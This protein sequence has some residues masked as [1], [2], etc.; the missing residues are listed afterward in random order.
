MYQY[1]FY[2]RSLRT[3]D[4]RPASPMPASFA[5]PGDIAWVRSSYWAEHCLE[6]GEPLCYETCELFS[7][8]PDD[9]CRRFSFGIYDNPRFADAPFGAE[10]AFR[11]WGKLESIVYP[12]SLTAEEALKSDALWKARCAGKRRLMGLGAL[13]RRIYPVEARQAFD[14]EKYGYADAA[15]SGNVRD[16][17]FFLLQLYSDET[18]AFTLFFDI[19]DGDALS[20]REGIRISPGYNQHVVN[21]SRA[22]PGRDKLRMK[23]YPENNR[24][25]RIVLLFCELVQFVA[26]VVPVEYPK[27][28]ADAAGSADANTGDA[29]P[30]SANPQAKPAKKV[31][32][33]AWDL[34]NTVWDGTFVESDPEELALRPGV[35]DTM[36]ALDDRGIIQVVVSKNTESEVKPTLD[37]LG[38]SDWFVVLFVNWKPKSQNLEAAADLLNINIDTFALID[39]SSFEREEVGFSLP[40]VRTYDETTVVAERAEGSA[41]SGGASAKDAASVPNAAGA[42]PI[43]A[44]PEFDVPVTSES[45]K[46]RQMYKTEMQRKEASATSNS[47]PLDFLRSCEIRAHLFHPNDDA[48]ILRSYELLQRTNQLNLSGNRYE[49]D[50]FFDRMQDGKAHRLAMTCGDRFGDYGQVLYL[51]AC[52]S[53]NDPS[54]LVIYEFALSC[55]VARKCVE[56]ALAKRLLELFE[57]QG[58]RSIELRGKRTDRNGLLIDSFCAAGFGNASTDDALVLR[59]A[60]AADLVTPD[61]VQVTG[62]D[63]LFAR[64]RGRSC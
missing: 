42:A 48:T 25:A 59:L 12:G 26:G 6:C 41:A 2:N 63:Q 49:K 19:T 5:K 57:P 1:E 10:I 60:S 32:C 43:F 29:A 34:D 40:M 45:K 4:T 64:E 52:V 22:F 11:K 39:D 51:E 47:D 23:I 18:D 55:R 24:E 46:R 61:V 50:V 21:A 37:R 17:P 20:F 8:R 56:A 31:K 27:A 15:G 16:T 58:V 7:K 44:L 54:L 3:G 53:K 13:G 36:K 14:S 33:V 62:G 28:Q 30:S 38:V 9:R 35:L